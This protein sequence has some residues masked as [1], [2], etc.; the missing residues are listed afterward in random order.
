MSLFPDELFGEIKEK[1]C[2]KCD[3]VLPFS[4]FGPASGANYL[5]YECKECT[6]KHSK[7]RKTLREQNPLTNPKSHICP[8]CER[9][10]NDVFGSGGRHLK[11]GW[12]M[13]HDHVTEKYRGYICHSCNRGLGMFQDDPKIL[14]NAANYLEKN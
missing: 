2:K 1:H 7:V 5:Y 12:V 8:I 13:D 11:S 4:A 14:R 10:F 6:R 3:R 9:T